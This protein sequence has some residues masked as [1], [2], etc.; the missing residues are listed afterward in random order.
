MAPTAVLP[1]GHAALDRQLPG[2]GWPCG[3]VTELLQPQAGVFEWRLLAPLLRLVTAQ[4]DE[5]VLI[6]APWRATPRRARLPGIDP[7]RLEWIDSETAA[8]RLW[9]VEQVLSGATRGAVLAW[10]PQ[11]SPLHL[12]RLQARA[13]WCDGP[14]FLM[15]PSS[16]AAERTS[17][18]LRLLVTLDA[19]RG[20][21]L[22]VIERR[23]PTAAVWAP[24]IGP[25]PGSASGITA[26]A[27]RCGTPALRVGNPDGAGSTA[28]R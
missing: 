3:A 27:P 17:A 16:A 1:S 7:A 19:G 12:R 26:P 6:G 28:Q 24:Q 9:A 2:G 21:Q 10:L 8:E 25:L 4:G 18:R 22:R 14:V 15:R 13:R 23:E 5:V 11:L 20:L